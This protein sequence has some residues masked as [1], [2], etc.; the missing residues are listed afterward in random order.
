VNSVPESK[1][2]AHQ[3]MNGVVIYFIGTFISKGL[4]LFLLPL[5]TAKLS[6]EQ[7]GYYDLLATL[8]MIL[9]P[10]LTV[11][12]IEAI[13]RFLFDADQKN[14]AELC[15]NVW[16][17]VVL[18]CLV[19]GIG[20]LFLTWLGGKVPNIFWF[21]WYYIA[22]VALNVLQ[23]AAR[24]MGANK[25]FAISGIIQAISMG[26]LQIIFLYSCL[27]NVNGLLIAYVIATFGACLYLERYTEVVKSFSYQLIN[28]KCIWEIIR[29]GLPLVPNN[30][31]W[32]GVS[33]VNKFIITYTLGMSATGIFAVTGKF[34]T[35]VATATN[36]FQ[37]AWQESAIISYK[38]GNKD[39]FNAKVFEKFG[40]FL[41][42]FC[43][44]SIAIIKI[45]LPFLVAKE[46]MEAWEY[47]PIAMV[48]ACFSAISLFYGAGYIASGETKDAFWT[49]IVGAIINIT[50]CMVLVGKIG[51][52]APL[53]ATLFG[54]IAIGFI[55]HFTM[56]KYMQIY[57]S[58][59]LI[60]TVFGML[61]VSLFSYYCG[62][63]LING[64]S[65]VFLIGVLYMA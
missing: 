31:S 48:G 33:A 25:A 6:P 41:F 16:L 52:Y 23:R 45:I 22:T 3:L 2:P 58:I 15:S 5:I 26:I 37:L 35:L 1:N 46:Y 19:L 11:Q 14:K 42:G 27:P 34:T 38:Q 51:L 32:W 65:A 43:S 13:F 9:M 53:S 28:K 49:T 21:Y 40:F 61:L 29:F 56:K 17:V 8:V 30:I 36:V 62:N 20:L 63:N 55:R 18:G 64:F 10:V 54:Y 50:L 24:S 12:V 7:Y 4:S 60:F 44:I 39:G 47:I 59:R 57:I